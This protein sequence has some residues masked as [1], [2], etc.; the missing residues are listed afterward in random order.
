MVHHVVYTRG[1]YS[2]Y[3]AFSLH[4][5]PFAPRFFF[6]LL[7]YPPPPPSPRALRALVCV[8]PGPVAARALTAPLA[9]VPQKKSH[10]KA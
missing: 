10:R 1:I 5:H 8:G 3:S 6:E 7:F 9:I 4:R 2:P